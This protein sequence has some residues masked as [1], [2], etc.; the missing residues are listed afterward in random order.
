MNL[1][2]EQVTEIYNLG[3]KSGHHDTVE[4]QYV[5]IVQQDMKSYHS[6][7]VVETIEI[8]TEQQRYK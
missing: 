5:D 6:E 4:G 3:Y 7:E 1:T 8:S 2:K